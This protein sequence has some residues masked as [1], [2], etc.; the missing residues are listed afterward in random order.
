MHGLMVLLT[1]VISY[2][3]IKR[4]QAFVATAVALLAIWVILILTR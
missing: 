2:V 4:W 3:A 1:E